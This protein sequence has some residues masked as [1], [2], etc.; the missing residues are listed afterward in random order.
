MKIN[1]LA[2]EKYLPERCVPSEHLDQMANGVKGR[3]EK[4]TGVQFRYHISGQETVCEMGAIALKKALH[5]ASIKA[6]DIDLLIFAGASF[7]YPVP[8]NSV[9]IKSKITND[10]VNFPCIDIDSTCLSFLNSLDIAHVYLQAGRYR[11]IAIVC[12]EVSSKA[13]TPKDEKVFGLFGDAAVATII[14]S[15]E[16]LGYQ[17]QYVDFTNYPSGAMYAHV[18]I[19][20][21]INRGIQAKVSDSGYYFNMDGKH[22]IRLTIKHLNDFIAKLENTTLYTLTDFDK[23]IAHQTSKFGNEYFLNHFN[24]DRQKVTETLSIYGNCISASIPLGLEAIVNSDQLIK[25]KKLLL[26]GS[27]AGLSLGAM[28]LKFD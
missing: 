15:S 24:L 10:E 19:G 13:L 9:I 27:G 25:C 12:S 18:P 14:E 3:I 28:V 26:V 7:D 21:A 16:H 11:R 1:I 22:L 23:I 8:H 4:N 17:P 5:K 2:I 20:G 6:K